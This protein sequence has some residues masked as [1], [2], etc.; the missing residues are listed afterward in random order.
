MATQLFRWLSRSHPGTF[1]QL[2]WRIPTHIELSGSAPSTCLPQRGRTAAIPTSFLSPEGKACNYSAQGRAENGTGGA[3][4][5]FM[6]FISFLG[7][8]QCRYLFFRNW[9]ISFLA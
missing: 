7:D 9:H 3:C 5:S 6:H 8:G 1:R 2:F 4:R